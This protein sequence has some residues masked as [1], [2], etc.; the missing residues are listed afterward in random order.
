[1]QAPKSWS[2]YTTAKHN[3]GLIFCVRFQIAEN[4]KLRV[5]NS[6]SSCVS[7]T[8]DL[9][10]KIEEDEGMPSSPESLSTPSRSSIS[11]FEDD[12]DPTFNADESQN[13]SDV[14]TDDF[15]FRVASRFR[16]PAASTN[17]LQPK[18]QNRG[19]AGKQIQSCNAPQQL[20]CLLW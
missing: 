6:S 19:S 17:D 18:E 8:A 15:R 1:M 9:A 4:A 10:L 7:T 16:G 2:K 12:L 14:A 5:M 20:A 3:L 11:D 13:R